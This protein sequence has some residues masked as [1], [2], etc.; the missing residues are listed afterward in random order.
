MPEEEITAKLQE[1]EDAGWEI[2]SVA[3]SSYPDHYY[4]LV[5]RKK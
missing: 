2:V 3:A 1:C 4:L 5:C